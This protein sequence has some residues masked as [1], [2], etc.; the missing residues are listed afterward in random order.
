MSFKALLHILQNL[1][2]ALK[3][4]VTPG[5]TLWLALAAWL[6]KRRAKTQLGSFS[7]KSVFFLP[8]MSGWIPISQGKVRKTWYA[9]P[10]LPGEESKAPQNSRFCINLEFFPQIFNSV[11]S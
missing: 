10:E 5:G 11:K 2:A 9:G 6:A 4:A 8:P 3:A 1:I 7:S